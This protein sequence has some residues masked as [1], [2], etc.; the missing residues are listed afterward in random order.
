MRHQA[1]EPHQVLKPGVCSRLEDRGFW[2]GSSPSLRGMVSSSQ[3]ASSKAAKPSSS[4]LTCCPRVE[5][6]RATGTMTLKLMGALLGPA[7]TL[8]SHHLEG[9]GSLQTQGQ[10]KTRNSPHTFTLTALAMVSAP[11]SREI[12]GLLCLLGSQHPFPP[13]PSGPPDCTARTFQGHCR[14]PGLQH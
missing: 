14:G 11:S 5:I 10:K 7:P 12:P 9:G 1:P 13:G 2:P 8:R 6:V 4:W 3:S